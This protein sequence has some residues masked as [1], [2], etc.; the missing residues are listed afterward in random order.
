[1]AVRTITLD[2]TDEKNP[3]GEEFEGRIWLLVDGQ[4]DSSAEELAQFAKNSDFCTLVG[5]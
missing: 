1:M 3:G 5:K 2:Y 4:V